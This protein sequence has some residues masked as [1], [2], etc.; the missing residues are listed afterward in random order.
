MTDCARFV[1]IQL[2]KVPHAV[3]RN[4][5]DDS[6][7]AVGE[8]GAQIGRDDNS[9]RAK[10]CQRQAPLRVLVKLCKIVVHRRVHEVQYSLHTVDAALDALNRFSDLRRARKD[11]LDCHYKQQKEGYR[12]CSER[13]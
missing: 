4:A 7:C 8:F 9:H 1:N 11:A 5:A 12:K 2:S 10:A 6:E 3:E 13:N